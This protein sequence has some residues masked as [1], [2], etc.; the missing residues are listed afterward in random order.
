MATNIPRIVIEEESNSPGGESPPANPSR[1]ILANAEGRPK[2]S[3]AK[4]VRTVQIMQSWSKKVEKVEKAEVVE[5]KQKKEEFARRFSRHTVNDSDPLV[6]VEGGTHDRRSR[7]NSYVAVTKSKIRYCIRNPYLNPM[8]NVLYYW[9]IVISFAALYNAGVIIARETFEQLQDEPWKLAIWFAFD[10]TADIIYII[11]MIVQC[12][13][14]NISKILHFTLSLSGYLE[15]GLVVHETRK[16]LIHYIKTKYRF[17]FLDIVSILPLDL[18]YIVPE[19]GPTHTILRIN[20]IL[21]LHRL[22]EYFNEADSRTNYPNVYRIFNLFLYIMLLI[23]W[24]ACFYFIISRLIGLGS[25]DWV[26]PNI[27][28]AA[29]FDNEFAS[30]S[31]QYLYSLYWSTLTL[32]TIG[33]LPGP[34]T[35]WEYV[36]VI[37]NFLAGVFIFATIVGMVGG[38][39][40]NMNARKTEFQS[41]LDN[42][43]Q[44]MKYRGVGKELQARVIKWFTYNWTN[45]HSLDEQE[46]LHT[47]P[48][49]LHAEIAIQ[50]HMDT[51]SKV[52]LFEE[53]EPGLLQ[54]LV[55]KLTSQVGIVQ[56]LFI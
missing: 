32:T 19:I 5:E 8:T 21:R 20:R 50:V 37:L 1:P 47:L 40:T 54:E 28:D 41:R 14:G 33:E 6:E 9:L 22:I 55:V 53:C 39:I 17:F 24:N 36:F 35:D 30:I 2:P 38:I 46:I 44:Y 29:G 23:H 7:L 12:R 43:K 52:K 15:Q 25:D 26:Y 34:I 4:A 31:R 11:D 51:L 42:I 13:T 10:Y 3:F 16:M 48:D 27:T 18:L 49:K 56:K 45:K